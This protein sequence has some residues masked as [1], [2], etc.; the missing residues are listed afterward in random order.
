[1]SEIVSSDRVSKIVG[2]GIKK[3]NFNVNSPNLPQRITILGEVNTA[4]QTGLEDPPEPVEL[5][6]LQ[7]VGTLF[8][9]GSPIYMIYRIL[10]PVSNDGVGGIP[11]KAFPQAEA[12]GATSKIITVT[13]SGTATG[14][15]IHT[16]VMAGRYGIDGIS[17]D[18]EIE[19]GDDGA[20]V[21]AKMET[22]VNNVLGAPMTAAGTDYDCAFESKWKGL[23]ANGLNIEVDTNGN[24]LGL[25]YA[26]VNT[27]SGAA[28]P[29][30]EEI[31]EAL[32]QFGNEWTTIVINSYGTVTS[33]MSALE[34]FNG[35]PDPD[36]PTGRYKGTIM[37]P[38][39]ALTGSV[40]DDPSSITD[41]RLDQVTIA[42]CPAPGSSGLPMEAAANMAYLFANQA[43][44]T[45][46]LDVS[47]KFYPD[48]PTPSN[49]GSMSVYENRD[50]IVKKGCSTVS[51]NVGKYQVQDFVTTYHPVG[52][53]P[54]HFRCCRNLIIDFNVRFRYFLLEEESVVDH[55]IAN[56]QDIVTAEKVIKPKQWKQRL[57]Q[58]A[59]DLASDALIVD[60]EFMQESVEV[61]ISSINPD[62]FE[63]S[64][65]YK[66]SGFARIAVTE[67]TAGFNFGN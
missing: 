5:T 1:M 20:D 30:T 50:T 53:N 8:G 13:A 57:N 43:Q 34:A 44:N 38:F 52:E 33:V 21:I 6:S 55:A 23:T 36:V 66:R 25:A 56:D 40:A 49:I 45:P 31:N 61:A 65:K 16:V 32:N 17:F 19:E 29:S 12:A 35:I 41:S 10:R 67:A 26:V 4:N 22:A 63:T 7:Q 37:K 60:A 27:Q 9:Y 15:G 54:P 24:D 14:N 28:T 64:F 59:I 3:G 39:I 58:L 62:R 47:G 51:L 46:H 48:M 42:I 11:I 18:I 2:Y